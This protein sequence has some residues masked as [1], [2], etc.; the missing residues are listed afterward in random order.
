MC[1]CVAFLASAQASS[2][3]GAPISRVFTPFEI[4]SAMRESGVTINAT[5]MPD[6][7]FVLARTITEALLSMG[8]TEATAN[9]A[10][11]GFAGFLTLSRNRQTCEELFQ[12]LT[13]EVDGNLDQLAAADAEYGRQIMDYTWLF[14][15]LAK[16]R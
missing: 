4:I 15:L 7:V 14:F 13:V 12:V 3:T 5:T 16:S 1:A 11:E 10:V 8:V 6:V 9:S 2:E